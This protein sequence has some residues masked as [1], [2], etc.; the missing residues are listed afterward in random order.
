MT[1]FIYSYHEAIGILGALAALVLLVA[2]I[3]M[4]LEDSKVMGLGLALLA[5][6]LGAFSIATGR[7]TPDGMS[8][9]PD[10]SVQLYFDSVPVEDHLRFSS[11]DSATTYLH[12]HIERSPK[13]RIYFT[14]ETRVGKI[15]RSSGAWYCWDTGHASIKTDAG[16]VMNIVQFCDAPAATAPREAAPQPQPVTILALP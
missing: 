10:G 4:F 7:I 9:K 16:L 3:V 15:T 1:S 12:Q 5:T 2:G 13:G 8:V 11:L 14:V 6:V